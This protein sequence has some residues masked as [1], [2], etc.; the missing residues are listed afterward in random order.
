MRKLHLHMGVKNLNKSVS[1]YET[2]FKSKPT[3]LKKDYAQWIL[4]DPKINFAISTRAEKSGVD[5]L[6]IQVDNSLE[7]NKIREDLDKAEIST[8]V[9]YTHLRAHETDS[10]LVC[11]LLL[12]KK[13]PKKKSACC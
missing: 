2:L 7:L 9:S 13:T 6:G 4:E 1:F 12:E 8:P 5:H 10:Y 11:R 3:K